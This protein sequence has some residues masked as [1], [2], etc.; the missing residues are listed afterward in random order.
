MNSNVHAYIAYI[1]GRL[2]AGKSVSSIHD[3]SGGSSMEIEALPDAEKLRDF[4]YINWS[5]MVGGDGIS[6]FKY[7]C[8][9]GSRL[10]ISI[11]GTAF[12]GHVA[13]TGVHFIG[14]VKGDSVHIYDQR[15]AAH[16]SYRISGSD[17]EH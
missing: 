3:C 1:V 17:I 16:F 6:R 14:R 12:L 9:D 13:H 2:I 11:K 8:A 7:P 5:Y 15:T 10:D 4:T